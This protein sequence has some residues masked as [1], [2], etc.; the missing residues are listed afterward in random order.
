MTVDRNGESA[1]DHVANA[2]QIMEFAGRGLDAEG[3]AA[4]RARLRK[5]LALLKEDARDR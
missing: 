2:L 5:A 1:H 3:F 4:V